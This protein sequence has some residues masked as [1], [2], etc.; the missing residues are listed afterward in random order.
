LSQTSVDLLNLFVRP[1]G[2][3]LYFFTVIAVTLAS[4]FM[5]LGQRLRRPDDVVTQRYIWALLGVIIA[6]VMLMAGALLALMSDREAVSVLPPLER[7]ASVMTLLLIGWAFLGTDESNREAVPVLMLASAIVVTVIG[8]G[9]TATQWIDLA[10][11]VD[12]NLS[13][14]G[15]T[16]TFAAA[17]LS[18]IGIVLVILNFNAVFDA[19]LKLVFFALLL[20]GYGGTLVQIAQGNIIGDY[21]GP[22]RLAF[23]A[24]LVILPA[25]IYRAIIGRLQSDVEQAVS[26]LRKPTIP[27]QARTAAPPRP[28]SPIERES[29]QLLRV[30]GMILEEATAESMPERIVQAVIQTL[31][32]DVAALLRMQDANYA[33]IDIAHDAAMKRAIDGISINLDNQPTLVTCIERLSQRGLHPEHNAEELQDFYTRLDIEQI[34]PLYFQPMTRDKE[35]V[36]ILVVAFPYTGRDLLAAEQEMLKGVAVIAGS[37]LALAYAANDARLLA[38]E[39]AIQAMVHGVPT[40]K[41]DEEESAA[42]A[43]LQANL[44]QAREQLAELN[45]QVTQLKLELDDERSRIAADLEDTEEGMTV[46]QQMLALTDEQQRLQAERDS[47]LQ[48]LQEAEAALQG[49]VPASDETMFDDMVE[50]LQREKDDLLVQRDRLQQQLEELRTGGGVAVPRDMQSMLER[51]AEERA[52]LQAERDQLSSKLIDIQSQLNSLGIEEGPAGL[53][54]LINQ[55]IEQRALLQTQNAVLKKERDRLLQDR[56]QFAQRMEHEEE[57]ELRIQSLQKELKNLAGDREAAVKQRDRLRADHDELRARLDSFREQQGNL[58]AQVSGYEQELQ[59]AHDTQSELRQQIQQLSDERSDLQNRLDRLLAEKH[60]IENERDQLI[61]RVEGDRERLEELGANG[62]GSLTAMINDLTEQRN[63][64]EHELNQSRTTLASLEN[65][66]EALRMRAGQQGKPLRYRPENPELMLGLVQELRTP[67]TSIIGYIDLLLGES[68]GILGEMQR[69]FLQRVSTNVQRLASMLEDLV[70]VTA[71]DTG[72]FALEP[73]PVDITSLIEDAITNASIQFREKGLSV[74]L[75][76]NDGLPQIHG[77]RDAISQVIG[78]L[79]TNA[80][81]VSPPNTEITVLAD[82]RQMV[83]NK[84]DNDDEYMA[85]CLYISVEDRGGGISPDDEPRVFARK[86]KA[87]NP[88]IQGLGDTG[89]GLSIARALVEAHGGRLWLETQRGRGSTFCLALPLTST[90]EP[91]GLSDA[92]QH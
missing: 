28:T 2:E 55:L 19:P 14:Y 22:V 36:A 29:V 41:I 9:L 81:L 51:M 26:A 58:Q 6:W 83:L 88:L 25:I 37:L 78:Q 79:L 69:K 87:E 73:G 50:A 15:V 7:F 77:D 76:L 21:A 38:E 17:A 4:L 10:G 16:W 56:V 45:Q 3:L 43:E 32:A 71:L 91:E 47:L 53:A 18:V 11:T 84:P 72:S 70:N 40:E 74:N 33:D 44:Q 67:M 39:R 46:S 90:T 61:A 27:T 80:Y 35:L 64:L 89:V 49:A 63:Q 75:N 62:I 66:L 68:A 60:R 13:A 23:V 65:E 54:H 12:F 57:R 31:K 92:S 24:A 82:Q 30:L 5:A 86:Y 85:D 52:Q 1:P 34:G 8:Y 42:R 59:E 20:I 48:R